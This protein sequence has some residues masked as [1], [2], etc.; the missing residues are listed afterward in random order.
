MD[1]QELEQTLL[2][3]KVCDPEA[4]PAASPFSQV[5]PGL[6]LAWDSTSLG[7]LKACPRKYY[8]S[9]ILARAPRGTSAHLDFGSYYHTALEVYDHAKALGADHDQ[10]HLV[11]LKCAMVLTWDRDMNRPWLSSIPEKT[12]FTLVR[13]VSW[14]LEQFKDDPLQTIILANG[15][16]AVELSFRFQLDYGPASASAERF[17]L[18]GHLD[19]LVQYNGGIYVVDRKTT[20]SALGES[21]FQQ[22]S[23]HNQ[24]TLYTIGASVVY[25]AESSGV[26]V[27]AAQIGAGF[28]RFQRRFAPRNQDQLEEYLDDLKQWLQM[29]E[30]FAVAKKWPMNETACS[31][32]GGCP[33]REL[34]SKP[35]SVREKFEQSVLVPKVWNPL[36]SR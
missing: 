34:C 36:Q 26:I 3:P 22:F 31:N 13:T 33:F 10:A 19:R 29:A 16:P 27:D 25:E 9:M 7:N 21:F 18:S 1:I 2:A 5:V 23:P 30:Q 20:K 32:Y 15:K 35:P 24:F 14:Y 4:P 11:A 6:Q 28:S 8:Y 17:M 12:R